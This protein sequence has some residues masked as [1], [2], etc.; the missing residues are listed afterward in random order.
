M[1]LAELLLVI[2]AGADQIP[3]LLCEPTRYFLPGCLDAWRGMIAGTF[4]AFFT[5]F[6][7]IGFEDIVN[8]AEEVKKPGKNVCEYPLPFLYVRRR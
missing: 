8:I 3:D 2:V 6:T 4:T 1:E 7:F 5:F